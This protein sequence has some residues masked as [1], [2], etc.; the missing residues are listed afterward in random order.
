MSEM[1]SGNLAWPCSCRERGRLTRG[2]ERTISERRRTIVGKTKVMCEN[3]LG[4]SIS[5]VL[6]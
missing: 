3:V 2:N 5:V 1:C 6:G 4:A